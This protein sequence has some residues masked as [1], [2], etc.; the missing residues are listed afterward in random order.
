MNHIQTLQSQQKENKNKTFNLL[1]KHCSP[2]FLIKVI[3]IGYTGCYLQLVTQHAKTNYINTH[4]SHSN[5]KITTIANRTKTK[6][7][8]SYLNIVL[9]IFRLS[10]L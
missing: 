9:H 6:H 1:F 8:T 3:L 7:S 4:E 5:I 2:H 10:K